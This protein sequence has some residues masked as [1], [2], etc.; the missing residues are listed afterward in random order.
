M[1]TN[2]EEKRKQLPEIFVDSMLA[3]QKD[4][5]NIVFLRK[6]EDLG[7]RYGELD[8]V[9]AFEQLTYCQ[10]RFQVVAFFFLLY[11]SST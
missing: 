1:T 11:W 8:E 7:V 4:E 2:T 10:Q 9:M 6:W 5:D 3:A